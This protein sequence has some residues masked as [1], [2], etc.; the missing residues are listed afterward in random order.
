VAQS[1]VVFEDGSEGEDAGVDISRAL[2]EGIDV[3]ANVDDALVKLQHL[4][5]AKSAVARCNGAQIPL[6]HGRD[7]TESR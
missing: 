3:N 1:E 6:L 7:V 4:R 5:H 2:V